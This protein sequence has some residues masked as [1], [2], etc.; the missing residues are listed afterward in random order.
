MKTEI[1]RVKMVNFRFSEDEEVEAAL[2]R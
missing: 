1:G 2:A